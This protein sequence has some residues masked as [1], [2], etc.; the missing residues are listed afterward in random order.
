MLLLKIYIFIGFIFWIASSIY[1]IIVAKEYNEEQDDEFSLISLEQVLVAITSL[2]V[3]GL[4]WIVTFLKIG[5]HI[6]IDKI[7]NTEME[8]NLREQ[9]L[10]LLMIGEL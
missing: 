7:I 1:T 8:F 6:C 3:L 4:I 5:L 10:Y 2:L 9:I